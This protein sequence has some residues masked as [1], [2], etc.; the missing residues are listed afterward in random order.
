MGLNQRGLGRSEGLG[1]EPPA[2]FLRRS[3]PGVWGDYCTTS[4]W[5]TDADWL[6]KMGVS[7]PKA[8]DWLVGVAW[9]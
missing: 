8:C 1:A 5:G 9:A 4:P 7:R 2:S 6:L 3:R